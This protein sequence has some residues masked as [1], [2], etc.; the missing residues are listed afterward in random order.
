MYIKLKDRIQNLR[1]WRYNPSTLTLTT[2]LENQIE[3]FKHQTIVFLPSSSV[4]EDLGD[5]FKECGI[6]IYFY[7]TCFL[8]KQRYCVQAELYWWMA[9]ALTTLT[10]LYVNTHLNTQDAERSHWEA[11]EMFW[12]DLISLFFIF[13]VFVFL[14][15]LELCTHAPHWHGSCR[16]H[17]RVQ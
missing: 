16:P 5:L 11:K 2:N 9:L 6:P 14:I 17:S 4:L 13:F 15:Y 7:I 8:Y 10:D 12:H 3:L 1:L